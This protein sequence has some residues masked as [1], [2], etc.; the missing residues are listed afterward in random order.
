MTNKPVYRVFKTNSNKR[1]DK[2]EFYKIVDGKLRYCG[3]IF[4]TGKSIIRSIR[5]QECLSKYNLVN[6]I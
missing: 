3:M 4:K 2:F 6:H 5:C 1:T